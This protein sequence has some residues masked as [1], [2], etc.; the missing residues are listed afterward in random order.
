MRKRASM[1]VALI[2]LAALA[3]SACGGSDEAASTTTWPDSMVVL[4]H[5]G[6]TGFNSDPTEPYSDARENSWATGSNPAV[7]SLY[8]R[9]LAQNPA[10]KGHNANLAKDGGTIDD[11]VEQARRA[12]ELEPK[13]QLVVIQILDNDIA[14]DGSDPKRY[15]PFGRK[16]ARVLRHL[17]T[18]DPGVR[19]FVVS[20]YGRPEHFFDAVKD[21]PVATGKYSGTGPC[22]A[23]DNGN[24]VPEHV[25]YLTDV[26]ESYEDQEATACKRFAGCYFSRSALREA[27]DSRERMASD[28]DHLSVAG[29]KEAA[30][31][32]W[33]ELMAAFNYG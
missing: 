32:A 1:R 7:N 14:C 33:P 30:A 2:V 13:P 3:L 6:A 21:D 26:I 24:L 5:S 28:L 18:R 8:R 17:T 25:A 23:F 9:I 29:H 11:L 27:A 16:F 4:G 20:Q 15:A 31:V 19:I 10:I 22:D 12:T